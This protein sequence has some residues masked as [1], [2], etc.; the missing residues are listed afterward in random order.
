MIYMDGKDGSGRAGGINLEQTALS[1]AITFIF[2][3]VILL[4]VGVI[5]TGKLLNQRLKIEVGTGQ[6]FRIPVKGVLTIESTGAEVILGFAWYLI[7]LLV[8]GAAIGG[9]VEAWVKAQFGIQPGQFNA[10][11]FISSLGSVAISF[12]IYVITKTPVNPAQVIRRKRRDQIVDKLTK[13]Q[14]GIDPNSIPQVQE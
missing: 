7:T 11:G 4:P 8:L 3:W 12:I 5:V 10:L 13:K 1:S 2:S 9:H 14:T 6:L